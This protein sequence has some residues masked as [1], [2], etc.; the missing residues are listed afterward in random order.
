[1]AEKT[2]TRAA[3]GEALVAWGGTDEHIVVLDADLSGSTMSKGFAKA[4]PERF[5]NM[6]IA[7]A[8]MT[9]SQRVWQPAA[10]NLFAILLLYFLRGV[11]GNRCATPSLIPVSMSRLWVHTGAFR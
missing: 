2:A 11:H 8:N 4:F 7:E 6:G 9:A 10:K 5:F 3:Y 1:M